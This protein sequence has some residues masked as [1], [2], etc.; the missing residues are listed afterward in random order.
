[1]NAQATLKATL[2]AAAES[3]AHDALLLAGVS[4]ERLRQRAAGQSLAA[5]LPDAAVEMLVVELPEP[6][7]EEDLAALAD[8][9]LQFPQTVVL[10]LH[11]DSSPER[12][13]AAMR[14]GIREMLPT[15]VLPQQ[16]AQAVQRLSQRSAGASAAHARGRLIAFVAASGG[17]SATV[18]AC[19][20][21]WLAAA[22]HHRSTVYADLDLRYGDASY[23]IGDGQAVGNIGELALEI[24]RL[25]GKLLEA[26]LARI[27]PDFFLLASPAPNFDLEGVDAQNMGTVLDIALQRH[28]LVV[29]EV[30][31]ELDE[32][33]QAALQRAAQVF[34][35]TEPLLPGLRDARNLVRAVQALGVPERKLSLVVNRFS[36]S[37]EVTLESIE[38]VTGLPVQHTVPESPVDWATALNGGALLARIKPSGP[39][40]RALRGM[41]ESVLGH[42]PSRP[43]GWLQRLWRVRAT[44]APAPGGAARH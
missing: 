39:I 20:F 4:L 21:A 18:L 22:E 44:P 36:R 31:R 32:V 8:Y 13:K 6:S 1:M 10:A 30:D 27:A 5:C 26:S 9:T 25:D 42:L 38:S 23:L 12:L 33:S 29:L 37:G 19:N 28:D 3:S 14:A 43:A 2:V 16:L 41:V 35:V 40:V 15:P 17:R 24:G 7:V 11:A 34:I